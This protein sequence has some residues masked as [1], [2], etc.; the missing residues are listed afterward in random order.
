MPEIVEAGAD[1]N[2]GGGVRRRGPGHAKKLSHG[3]RNGE[4]FIRRTKTGRLPLKLEKTGR[5]KKGPTLKILGVT[6][7]L[8]KDVNR[9]DSKLQNG[10]K[11]CGGNKNPAAPKTGW[12]HLGR[13]SLP[14]RQQ[15]EDRANAA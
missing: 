10:Q 8:L 12:K 9:V 5:K 4:K 2:G 14:K 11:H 13:R 3:M 6:L 7:L 15:A 1:S